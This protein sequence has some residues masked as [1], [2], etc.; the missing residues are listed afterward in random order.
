VTAAAAPLALQGRR[1]LVTRPRHQAPEFARAL[2]ALGAEVEAVA[3]MNLAR[4]A[5]PAAVAAAVQRCARGDFDQVVFTSVNAVSL[6]MEAAR[7]T[8]VALGSAPVRTVAIGPATARALVAAGWRAD[9]VPALY[10]AEAVADQMVGEGV[11]GQRIWLPRAAEARPVLLERLRAAG[12]T[13]E[14]LA[15]YRTATALGE[16][17]RLQ[18]LLGGAALDAI[19]FTSSSTVRHF[20]AVRGPVPWPAGAAVACIG[21]VTA[22]TAAEHG[23]APDII[24]E[25]HTGAGLARALARHFAAGAHPG[26]AAGGG[27]P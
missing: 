21:P 11:G 3:V 16:R 27:G 25:E 24:A 18:R 17:E 5:P 9:R 13:V 19:T 14:V 23:Y 22:Q 26:A 4:V 8:G 10:V 7:Q 6:V 20:H 1:I 2:E 15:L 12:A